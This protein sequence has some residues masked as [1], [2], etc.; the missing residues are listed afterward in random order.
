MQRSSR[1]LGCSAT[2]A[3]FAA[4]AVS[5]LCGQTSH[6]SGGYFPGGS[7]SGVIVDGEGVP[8]MG[9]LVQLLFPDATAAATALTDSNGRY[10][11]SDLRPGRYRVRVSA[12]LFLPAVRQTLQVGASTRAVVNLTLS[13]LLAPTQWLPSTRRT[14]DAAE[15]DWLWTLRSSTIRPVMRWDD[16]NHGSASI[17]VSSSSRERS[18]VQF[19]GRVAVFA[20]DGGFAHGGNHEVLTMEKTAGTG[21]ASVLRADFSGPRVP[22]PVAPSAEVSAGWGRELPLG[23]ATRTV[24]SYLS[25]PELLNEQGSN[26]MQAM[27]LRNAERMELG[28]T[29]RVDAGSVTRAFNLGGN[30]IAMEPFLRLAYRPSSNVIIAYAFTAARGISQ[31]EDLDRIA[32]AT[33]LGVRRNGH[34]QLSGGHSNVISVA[35]RTPRQGKLQAEAYRET[36]VAPL[37]AGVG[38]LTAADTAG[39][40]FLSDPT[41]QTYVLA[42]RDF[43]GTGVRISLDQ[44]ISPHITLLASVADGSALTN[45]GQAPALLSTAASQ[46]GLHQALSA[47]ARARLHFTKTGTRAEAGYRWQRANTLT[48]VDSFRSTQDPA[49]LSL[50]LRQSLQRLPLLPNGLEAVVQ[51]QNLLAQGYQPYLS[52]DGRT[53]YLAQSPRMLQAGVSFTF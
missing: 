30:T 11:V 48:A 22:Y 27:V 37:L 31:F 35:V 17:G 44:P 3:F 49:Y 2:V 19:Q 50:V 21:S 14:A 23:S 7:V 32:P 24:V 47:T 36:I 18:R 15:D 4:A 53:L 46:S 39:L 38:A 26:G 10:H 42:G 52:A 25:H 13:T 9:A 1:I 45:D 51:V 28:D 12:A 20:N 6:G 34:L 40:P 16:D 8:Q 33:P 5:P 43:S 29:F 41:T